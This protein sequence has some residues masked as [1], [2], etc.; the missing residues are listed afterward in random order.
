[1]RI[2]TFLE[3]VRTETGAKRAAWSD[4]APGQIECKWSWGDHGMA[5]LLSDEEPDL[6][7]VSHTLSK[8]RSHLERINRLET[9]RQ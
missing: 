7:V 8:V 5:V 3:V 2:E 6:S 4:Y 9:G 1:M